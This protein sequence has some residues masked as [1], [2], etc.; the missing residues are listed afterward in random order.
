MLFLSDYSNWSHLISVA[1]RQPLLS[2]HAG[3]APWKPVAFRSGQA[4]HVFACLPDRLSHRGMVRVECK[5]YPEILVWPN[6]QHSSEPPAI[7]T[8]RVNLCEK[9]PWSCPPSLQCAVICSRDRPRLETDLGSIISRGHPSPNAELVGGA[10]RSATVSPCS[11]L[12]RGCDSP[13]LQMAAA[14]I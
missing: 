3:A 10:N 14:L 9:H 2:R 8:R 4:F 6:I 1:A 13:N 7:G 11:P 5:L 12:V